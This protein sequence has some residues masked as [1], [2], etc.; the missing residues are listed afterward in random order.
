MG[1]KMDPNQ[2]AAAVLFT[3]LIGAVF[4]TVD[5]FVGGSNGKYN[6]FLDAAAHAGS[7]FGFPLTVLTCPV[8]T[9]IA[10]GSW[11]RCL[12]KPSTEAEGSS[13]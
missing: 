5:V 3:P 7:P 1:R 8:L 2:W 12:V 4:F 6:N 11:I 13:N 9:I 10:L